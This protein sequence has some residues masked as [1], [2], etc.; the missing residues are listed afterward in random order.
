MVKENDMSGDE[1]E[2]CEGVKIEGRWY[3]AEE[4][5]THDWVYLDRFKR[6]CSKCHEKQM[7]IGLVN[8]EDWRKSI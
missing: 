7:Y 2:P 6:K 8:N 5:Y 3:R 4:Y 1:V